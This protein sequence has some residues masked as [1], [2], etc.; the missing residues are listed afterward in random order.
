MRFVSCVID[1]KKGITD[2][3]L[4]KLKARIDNGDQMLDKSALENFRKKIIDELGRKDDKKPPGAFRN[5]SNSHRNFQNTRFGPNRPFQRDGFRRNNNEQFR[6]NH[7]NNRSVGSRG[8]F[9]PNRNRR[10]K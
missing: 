3:E 1:K 9:Q 7:T 10:E 6:R 2:G 5:N 4:K 8:S